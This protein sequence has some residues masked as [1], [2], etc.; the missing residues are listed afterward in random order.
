M[1]QSITPMRPKLFHRPS[2]DKQEPQT[3]Q[4]SNVV[5]GLR[6]V[7]KTIDQVTDVLDV[8]PPGLKP[9]L[10]GLIYVLDAIQ[11]SDHT[12]RRSQLNSRHRKLRKISRISNNYQKKSR[13]C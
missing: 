4:L 10:T 6:S 12:H 2:K 1:S 5:S 9:C 11:V 13:I 8:G 7:V 3:F